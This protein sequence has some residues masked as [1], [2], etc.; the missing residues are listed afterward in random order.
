MTNEEYWTRVKQIAQP[1]E[2][3]QGQ[4]NYTKI[5]QK[6]YPVQSVDDIELLKIAFLG[7]KKNGKYY[8][9][10]ENVAKK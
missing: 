10:D 8:A 3:I 1:L 9:Y 4:E 2:I 7:F 5:K 6:L